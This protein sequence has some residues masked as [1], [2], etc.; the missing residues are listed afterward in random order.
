MTKK[1]VWATD[2]H[3]DCAHHEKKMS[4]LRSVERE[5]PD[6][7]LLTGDISTSRVLESDLRLFEIHLNEIST[8][9]VLGNHD[10][11]HD[12][13]N[14]IRKRTAEFH[15]NIGPGKATYALTRYHI[16]L[17]DKTAL[18][19]HDGWYDGIYANWFRSH[20]V[21]ADYQLIQE[22]SFRSCPTPDLRYN[23]IQKQAR[24]AAE[25]VRLGI[26]SAIDAGFKNIYVMTHVPPFRENSVYEGKISDDDW[27]PHFSSAIMG[28]ELIQQAAENPDVEFTVLCGHSHGEATHREL[29]NLVCHT[30]KAKYKLPRI[31]GIFEVP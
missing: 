8:I 9:F 14:N 5:K 1:L 6:F 7:L 29:P 24:I 12:S 4:F 21:L 22:L 30:G 17:S 31:A 28:D 25:H 18:V 27:M 11:Y 3:F 10:Y 13:I 23:T 16:P 19:G 2:I 20:V 26:V 15:N